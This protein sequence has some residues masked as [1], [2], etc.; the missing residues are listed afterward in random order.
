MMAD[1]RAAQ[2]ALQAAFRATSA[3]DSSVASLAEVLPPEELS[4]YKRAVGY[5]MAE[6]FERII[7][8]ILREHPRLKPDG[9]EEW[10]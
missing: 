9:W 7:H 5:V 4:A 10:L 6:A 3:L 8:P 2:G 1:E